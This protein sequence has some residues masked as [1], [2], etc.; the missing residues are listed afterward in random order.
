MS[1]KIFFLL[2]TC[3]VFL[4]NQDAFAQRDFLRDT[5]RIT[6][7]DAEKFFLEKNFELLAS[8]YRVNEAEAAVVQAKLWDNPSLSFEQG[9]HNNQS[10]KWFDV[11]RSGET[12]VSIDQLI[13]LAGKRNKRI[14]VEKINTQIAGYQFYDLMRTL[15]YELHTTFYS[16]HF[17]YESLS[18]Y[19]DELNSLKGLLDAYQLQFQKGNSSFRELARLQALQFNLENE[20]M[21]V[22][23]DFSEK[24]SSL[25]LMTGDTLQRVILPV[26]S[27]TSFD[28][29]PGIQPGYSQLLDSALANRP[30]FKIAEVEIEKEQAGLAL[31]KSLRVPDLH[32]GAGYD[33][34]GSYINDYNFISLG[35]D[36]P[37]FNRNQGNIKAAG[38][39]LEESKL[40][41]TKTE[42]EVKNDVT[43]TLLRFR[44]TDRLYKLSRQQFSSDYDKLKEG[45]TKGYE[46]HVISLLEFID[47]FETYKNS[48][49]EFNRLQYN[50]LEAIENINLATGTIIFK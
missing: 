39:Q 24:E 9:A 35:I 11:S 48:K 42:A 49:T 1:R 19:D 36:L 29:L 27:G 23:K 3:Q 37:F 31:Q 4:H 15:R 10:G 6:L 28:S 45:I 33:R 18:V 7:P 50:R 12:A 5:V 16:L 43:K 2:M 14:Q 22:L 25:S 40:D 13:C 21:D 8:R 30:D 38:Y 26:V 17:L 41:K 20:R 32:V 34:A 44:E 46:Q 47:Y